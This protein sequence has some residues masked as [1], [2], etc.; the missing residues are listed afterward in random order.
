MEDGGGVNGI[1]EETRTSSPLVK[2]SDDA[3]QLTRTND[4]SLIPLSTSDAGKHPLSEPVPL[5]THAGDP[6]QLVFVGDHTVRL[7]TVLELTVEQSTVCDE[8]TSG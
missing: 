2:K 5:T 4:F 7:K 3:L 8:L 1:G 6:T